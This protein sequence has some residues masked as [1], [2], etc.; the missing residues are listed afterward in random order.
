LIKLLR[1]IE[2][3]FEELKVEDEGEYWETGNETKRFWLTTYTAAM[4]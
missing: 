4:R 2:Q 1:D 3:F